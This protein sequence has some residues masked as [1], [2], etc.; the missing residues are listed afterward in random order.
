M[1]LST[2]RPD[3]HKH[4]R[5]LA[6]LVHGLMASRKANLV[7]GLAITDADGK[8]RKY[9]NT[10][11]GKIEDLPSQQMVF[12]TQTGKLMVVA[13]AGNKTISLDNRVFTE[14]DADGFFVETI[15]DSQRDGQE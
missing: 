5:L 10:A 3:I 13:P 7:E 2:F 14:M 1:Y 15:R 12:D 6:T 11:N 8:R 9:V 4:V